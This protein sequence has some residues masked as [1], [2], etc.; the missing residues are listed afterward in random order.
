MN[1][2]KLIQLLKNEVRRLEQGGAKPAKGAPAEV[3]DGVKLKAENAR[4]KN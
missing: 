2:D 3:P 4:L 1:D